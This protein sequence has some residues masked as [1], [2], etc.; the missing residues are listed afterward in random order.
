VAGHRVVALERRGKVL[1]WRFDN[2]GTVLI[3]LGMS[4]RIAIDAKGPP[5]RHDHLRFAIDGGGTVTFHDAR[6]FGFVDYAPLDTLSMDPLLSR[7]G[8]EPLSDDFT[9]AIL[10]NR[11]IGRRG[12]IKT[13]LLD[14]TVVA[15]LGN[16]Y[17]CEALFRA[18]ISPLCVAESLSPHRVTRLVTA[19]Q[20]VLTEAVAAGGS[21]LK[22]H[23]QPNGAL[24]YFQMQFSVYDR[25]GA[26]C[27]RQ[28]GEGK[29]RHGIKRIVQAGRSTY[30]CPGCQN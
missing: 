13:V 1:L 22:D 27:P 14:Q 4:G 9:A 28:K 25:E 12:P 10:K 26:A 20:S 7:L 15:G 18:G 29:S 11:L 21:T 24:G 30:Y 16:I 8:P 6:R 17:V 23:R 19:I 2:G 5:E 3:H